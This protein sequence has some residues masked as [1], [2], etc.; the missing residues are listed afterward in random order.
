MT[1][2]SNVWDESDA[3]NSSFAHRPFSA[4]LK[5][6]VLVGCLILPVAVVASDVVF[7]YSFQRLE[8]PL[9][10]RIAERDWDAERE[11]YAQS[12]SLSEE[13]IEENIRRMREEFRRITTEDKEIR[14][15]LTVLLRG[16]SLAVRRQNR[17]LRLGDRPFEE[18]LNNVVEVVTPVAQGEFFGSGGPNGSSGDGVVEKPGESGTGSNLTNLPHTIGNVL[19]AWIVSGQSEEFW[20]FSQGNLRRLRNLSSSEKLVLMLNG[21]EYVF[22]V[23]ADN[24]VRR[25]TA[26]YPEVGAFMIVDFSDYV[27]G[28]EG[29]VASNI[30]VLRQSPAG[31]PQMQLDLTLTQVLIDDEIPAE[32]R[33]LLPV[34]AHV[35]DLRGD[36]PM[37]YTSLG[38]IPESGTSRSVPVW[39]VGSA[40]L[41]TIT[42]ATVGVFRLRRR[43][44]A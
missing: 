12:T 36:D 1:R 29:R 20:P 43:D 24:T 17:Q 39:I 38:G 28:A 4:A 32:D 10:A 26:G 42:L 27:S 41:L 30:R 13:M 21:N 22:E 16:K 6:C 11:R 33:T 19:A 40:A 5:V 2:A 14:G 23:N 25:V 15:E 3:R 34:G 9:P 7:T 44:V 35:T 8:H 31:D 37:T 18:R